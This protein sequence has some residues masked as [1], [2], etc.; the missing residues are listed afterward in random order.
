M[1]CSDNRVV[2]IIDKKN[3]IKAVLQHVI[4]RQSEHGI[5]YFI[6]KLIVGLVSFKYDAQRIHLLHRLRG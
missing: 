6:M 3:V 2:I 1:P 4:I 5:S